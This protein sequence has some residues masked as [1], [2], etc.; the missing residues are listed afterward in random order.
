MPPIPVASAVV[1][2]RNAHAQAERIQTA[3]SAN[4]PRQQAQ[5]ALAEAQKS[6]AMAEAEARDECRSGRKGRCLSTESREAAARERVASARAQLAGLGADTS[7]T[8]VAAVMGGWADTFSRGLA[9]APAVWL[10][11]AAPALLAFGFAPWPRKAVKEKAKPKRRKRKVKRESRKPAEPTVAARQRAPLRLVKDYRP[12][13]SP[14][15]RRAFLL[16]A[17]LSFIK[18]KR[19][20]LSS[21]STVANIAQISRWTSNSHLLRGTGADCKNRVVYILRLQ[22]WTHGG[23]PAS[24][25]AESGFVDST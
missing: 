2:A 22:S 13:Q 19:A 9:V 14:P 12:T 18:D 1:I 8:P 10:E 5:Q 3:K 20:L 17:F 24:T 23:R 21:C 25:S 6:L 15:H 16:P 7:E 11:C 4:L